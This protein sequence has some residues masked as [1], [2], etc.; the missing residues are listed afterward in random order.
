M[1]DR[2]GDQGEIAGARGDLANKEIRA[3]ETR[4]DNLAH[5]VAAML[6]GNSVA[7][8]PPSGLSELGGAGLGTLGLPPS[9]LQRMCRQAGF[10]RF[11]DGGYPANLYY[12]VRPLPCHFCSG[13]PT[14][15]VHAPPY[16]GVYFG[17]ARNVFT[18][19]CSRGS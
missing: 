3:G 15:A 12:E 16:S 9:Q 2:H 13:V 6:Y 7:S 11:Q 4:Q 10:S 18:N 17:D 8:C 19:V 1:S 5:P 14:P